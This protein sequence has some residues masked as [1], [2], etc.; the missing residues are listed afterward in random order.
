MGVNGLTSFLNAIFSENQN[1]LKDIQLNDC[2]VL[3]DGYSLLHNIHHSN[4]LKSAYGGNYDELA[5]RIEEVFE[6]FRQC[7]VEP[8]VLLDGGREIN[9][10]KFQTSLKRAD[11]RLS[12]VCYLNENS[13][14]TLDSLIKS[15][16]FKVFT[17]LL[18]IMSFKIFIDILRKYDIIHFQCNFE[19]DYEL[20]CLANQLKCH[21]LS[22][23]SDFYIYNLSY[24]YISLKD[25]LLD[26]VQDEQTSD[27]VYLSAKLYNLDLLLLHFNEK[28]RRSGGST[29]ELKKE[30]LSVFAILCGNDYVDSSLFG[31]LLSTFD[32]T[33]NNLRLKKFPGFAASYVKRKETNFN[34]ILEWLAKF[35]SLEECLQTILEFVKVENRIKIR[36]AVNDS[37][38]EYMCLK[39]SSSL[40][41]MKLIEEKLKLKGLDRHL[42][43]L[44][45]N[46]LD[47][48]EQIRLCSDCLQIKPEFFNAFRDC[49]MTR[50]CLDVLVHHNVIFG[51][52]IE[53]SCWPSSYL[54]S[55]H[56]RKLF[57]SIL[58]SKFEKSKASQTSIGINEY[59][60]YQNQMKIF[61]V[62]LADLSVDLNTDYSDF[63][64]EHLFLFNQS[65]V[66]HINSSSF[67]DLSKK[68]KLF[69]ACIQFWLGSSLIWKELATENLNEINC[70][71]KAIKN[72][73]CLRA[74]VVALLKCSVVDKCY[75]T[76]KHCL[77]ET[78]KN[79]NS[80]KKEN[81]LRY[82]A[83]ESNLIKEYFTIK[84]DEQF[85]NSLN[86]KITSNPDNFEYIKEVRIKL[87][88]FC[89][90]QNSHKK[91]TN[92]NKL[93]RLFNFKLIHCLCEF[94]AIYLSCNYIQEVLNSLGTHQYLLNFL[95]IQSFFNGSFLHNFVEEL[96]RRINPDL[97]IEE[98]FGRSSLFKHLYVE[99]VEIFDQL[100]QAN[101][102]EQND[103]ND[104]SKQGCDETIRKKTLKN[105]KK[106]QKKKEKKQN[107]ILGLQIAQLNTNISRTTLT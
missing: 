31:S 71:F 39:Q 89:L 84:E 96:E 76:M 19:A 53:V 73:N 11:Q 69:F 12:N 99:L 106:N 23:D 94:Q 36:E 37:F 33:N 45:S 43:D 65:L 4:C 83:N 67:T 10:R 21:I 58:T 64:Y 77:N 93:L 25:F 55:R 44:D 38:Q 22:F 85:L 98:L 82:F 95:S 90:L 70:Q 17:H 1:I 15:G 6:S 62:D 88:E 86:Q 8:I 72:K 57:Y 75:K 101:K 47:G 81:T 59:L 16:N 18:P 107:L 80:A 48:L 79:A 5:A 32:S 60:R 92:A 68:L 46:K 3:V 105:R 2:L 14:L 100:F 87:K 91:P 28:F 50:A 66:E 78:N 74:F 52:Q 26:P 49:K 56:I 24:G 9:D 42:K 104:E 63:V 40:H 51:C 34:R 13:K 35:D 7:Q 103:L 20:A 54:S 97:Y 61:Q 102:R 27:R 29:S 41:Y 30:M